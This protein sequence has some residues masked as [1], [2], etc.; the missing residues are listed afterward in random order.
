[1]KLKA[2]SSS[3]SSDGHWHIPM[4]TRTLNKFSKN[5]MFL[6]VCKPQQ[7]LTK[8]LKIFVDVSN[9]LSNGFL[10]EKILQSRDPIARNRL[11]QGYSRCSIG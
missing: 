2:A 5:E 8:G 3:Q 6:Y 10:R 11:S 9:P 7:L 1:M 4:D